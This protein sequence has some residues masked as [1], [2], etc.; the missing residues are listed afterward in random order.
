MATVVQQRGART[1][2]RGT[3][4][5]QMKFVRWGG[6]RCSL[7]GKGTMYTQMMPIIIYSCP[8]PLKVMTRA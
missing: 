1:L 4:G 3:T 6:K 7:Y 5:N 8:K 2:G